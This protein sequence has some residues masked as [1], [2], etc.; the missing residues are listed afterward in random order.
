MLKSYKDLTVWQK[1]YSLCLSIYKLTGGFPGE[2]KYALTSQ[3]RRA[4]VSVPPN[5]AEGYGRKST[6]INTWPLEPSNP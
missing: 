1:A 3:I 4:A 2:E 5:I 6:T